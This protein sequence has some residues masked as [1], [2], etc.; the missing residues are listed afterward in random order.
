MFGQE[1]ADVAIGYLIMLARHLGEIDRGVRQ[2]QW[3][4]P[5]G[6]SRWKDRWG[7]GFVI[8]VVRW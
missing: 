8:L 4:K 3:P 7:V 5:S 6:I 2:G 1:V